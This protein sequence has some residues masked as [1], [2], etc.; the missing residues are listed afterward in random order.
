MPRNPMA[1]YILREPLIRRIRINGAGNGV[2]ESCLRAKSWIGNN[3][4]H[5]YEAAAA[6]YLATGKEI[7]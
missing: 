6:H 4:G 1:I 5:L 2:M 7:Y 3:S